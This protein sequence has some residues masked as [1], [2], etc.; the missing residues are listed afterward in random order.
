[1]KPRGIYH[2]LQ[3]SPTWLTFA[4]LFFFCIGVV[5]LGRKLFEGTAYNV[6][7]S[8]KWGDIGLICSI[9]VAARILKRQTVQVRWFEGLVFP[10]TVLVVGLAIGVCLH[11]RTMVGHSWMFGPVMDAY[12]NLIVVPLFFFLLAL[13]LPI[14]WLHGAAIEKAL[15]LISLALWVVL[16]LYDLKTG[17]LDQRRWLEMHN[18]TLQ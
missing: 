2:W 14:I 7:L 4:V 16:V 10:I 3:Q 15:T 5:P 6:A 13:T 12:H 11:I 9:V 17:R 8:S 18:L 1:M